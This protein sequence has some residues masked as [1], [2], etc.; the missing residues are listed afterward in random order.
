[1]G[2]GHSHVAVL[3]RFG[4]APLPGVRVTL[5]SNVE[6]APYSGMLPG[7]IA[8]HYRREE[9]Q[10]ELRPLCGFAG[11]QFYRDTVTGLDLEHKRV[12]F[13]TR[14]PAAFDL[15][16]INIGSTPQMLGIP[17]AAKHALAVKPVQR[18]LQRW[19]EFFGP[20]AMKDSARRRLV[21][22]GGGAGGVELLLAVRHRL[23]E[24]AFGSQPGQGQAWEFHLVTA[25]GTVLP[26]HNRSVQKRY[27][28]V[29]SE[30]GV[31]V[32]LNQ[33]VVEVGPHQLF[34]EGGGT[35]PYDVL[36]WVTHA[37]APAWLRSSGLG[38]DDEGFVIFSA[39]L[40]IR[41]CSRR[42]TW[43]RWPIIPGRSP[44]CSPCVR[45]GPWP[46]ISAAR[47][48]ASP[49]GGLFRSASSSA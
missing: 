44:A 4:M 5:I 43:P 16:S 46:T 29:L 14:P 45:G 6:A 32:H 42:A 37:A 20:Q 23:L 25:S 1:V 30:R 40:H 13:A 7:C 39:R 48:P 15:L 49:C 10:I 26:S 18:F 41:S 22:V 36:L 9:S 2:G 33:R 35:V 47:W 21:V 38:T 27:Q 11:A 34:S 12:L 28:R 8:G 24:G 17:G 31:R 19:E 3:K